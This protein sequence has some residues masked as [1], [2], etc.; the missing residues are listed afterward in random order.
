M[1]VNGEIMIFKNK[2]GFS[3]TIGKKIGDE[4]ENKFIPLD[5]SK[6]AKEDLQPEH[7]DKLELTD[8]WLSF[9][10]TKDGE[11]VVTIFINEAD[12]LG[13][14]TPEEVKKPVKKEVKKAVKKS[15]KK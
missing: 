4:Y 14:G 2:R 3:T 6:S 5:F 10:T 7:M 13:N 12:Y 11:E 8:A 9:F 15:T 1:N